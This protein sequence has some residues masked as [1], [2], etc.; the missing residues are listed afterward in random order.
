MAKEYRWTYVV[1]NYDGADRL[2]RDITSFQSQDIRRF[3]KSFVEEFRPKMSVT[4]F[5]D[6]LIRLVTNHDTGVFETLGGELFS[7]KLKWEEVTV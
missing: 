6:I 4:G 5:E 7:A 1:A 3:T 2:P